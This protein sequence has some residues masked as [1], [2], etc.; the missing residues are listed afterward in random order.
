MSRNTAMGAALIALGCAFLAM[1][2]SGQRTFFAI[3]AAFI[4][5]GTVFIL[6]QRRVR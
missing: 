1:S 3:G 5:I 2:A 6:R 4:V